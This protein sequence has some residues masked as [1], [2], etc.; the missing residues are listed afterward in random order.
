MTRRDGAA[1]QEVAALP[2]APVSEPPRGHGFGRR[3]VA[4]F[5]AH[6]VPLLLSFP[7]TVLVARALGPADKGL[8][9]VLVQLLFVAEV[10]GAM[11]GGTYYA[12]ALGRGRS[13]SELYGTALLQ[14]I[15]LPTAMLVIPAGILLAGGGQGHGITPRLTLVLSATLFL[16][17]L[18]RL[19]SFM[20]IGLDRSPVDTLTNV[21]GAAVQ[22]IGIFGLFVAG[23]LNLE[24]AI[25]AWAVGV[26]ARLVVPLTYISRR[27]VP[28]IRP[29]L[30]AFAQSLRFGWR[31]AVSDL[32]D[33][34]NTR[35]PLFLLLLFRP[36][37]AVGVY[38]IAI[39]L[40]E[41]LGQAGMAISLASIQHFSPEASPMTGKLTRATT[42]VGGALMVTGGAVAFAIP[43][44]FGDAYQG[45]VSQLVALLPTIP[46]LA[47][48]RVLGMRLS[49]AKMVSTVAVGG[50]VSL[51]SLT[52]VTALAAP[53]MGATGATLGLTV[54]LACQAGIF[55]T[56]VAR[57]DS[58]AIGDLVIPRLTDVARVVGEIRHTVHL[59]AR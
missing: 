7:V 46:L 19:L 36:L 14:S 52:L 45:A 49:S 12:L 44:V 6:F 10:V 41:V 50:L 16:L 17:V 47:L 38:S 15:V 1:E 34:V 13:L 40:I 42:A 20:L 54:G 39:G 23:W 56:A 55:L 58:L 25:F 27:Y 11:G 53:H 32:E 21:V 2:P 5:G 29:R 26:L 48:N 18:S 9:T 51:G 28:A 37:S 3:T 8:W 59:R 43:I 30:H 22:L 35:M 4:L 24:S 31:R 57:Y 33:A